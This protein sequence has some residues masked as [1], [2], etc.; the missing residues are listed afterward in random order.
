MLNSGIGRVYGP[1]APGRPGETGIGAAGQAQ[2]AADPRLRVSIN[3][4][5][6]TT[7]SLDAATIRRIARLARLGIEETDIARLQGELGHIIGWIEQLSVL[8]V[9]GLEPISGVGQAALRMRADAVTDGDKVE[10]VLSN[11]PSRAGSFYSVPKV[12]E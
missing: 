11:A 8:D 10:A 9:D 12:V 4:R 3:D 5:K 7:M 2:S 1:S 6:L